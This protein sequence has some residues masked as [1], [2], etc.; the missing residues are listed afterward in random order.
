MHPCGLQKQLHVANRACYMESMTSLGG[1]N[2]GHRSFCV[3][4]DLRPWSSLSGMLWAVL[5]VNGGITWKAAGLSAILHAAGTIN[6]LS[7]DFSK[8]PNISSC[9]ALMVRSLRSLPTLPQNKLSVNDIGLHLSWFC[10]WN[11]ISASHNDKTEQG[12][13]LKN[14]QMGWFSMFH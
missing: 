6:T 3:R 12:L 7:Y 11:A 2:V 10:S 4:R 14:V 9:W 8:W 5:V 13:A 1:T